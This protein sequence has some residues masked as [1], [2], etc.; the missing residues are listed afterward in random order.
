M[1]KFFCSNFFKKHSVFFFTNFKT[2]KTSKTSKTSKTWKT[3]KSNDLKKEI[4]QKN[5]NAEEK[6]E[7]KVS[8]LKYFSKVEIFYLFFV[9]LT[10]VSV[11]IYLMWNLFKYIC[12]FRDVRHFLKIA[13][14]L[15]GNEVYPFEYLQNR[16]E[17]TNNE[18]VIVAVKKFE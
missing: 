1:I 9:P 11:Y 18:P 17:K 15:N 2:L 7:E 12:D 3:S 4:V 6:D 13:R 5:C 14:W 10:F 16:E 8:A